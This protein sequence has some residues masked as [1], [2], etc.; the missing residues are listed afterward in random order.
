M[1]QYNKNHPK[2]PFCPF[3]KTSSTCGTFGFRDAI[4]AAIVPTNPNSDNGAATGLIV[5]ALNH[6]LHEVGDG[7]VSSIEQAQQKSE[8]VIQYEKEHGVKLFRTPYEAA[9]EWGNEFNQKS[10]DAGREYGSSIFEVNIEGNDY[11]G[12]NKP[13]IGSNIPDVH[14]RLS[15]KVNLTLPPGS[16]LLA[17]IHSHSTGSLGFSVE[18]KV[19]AVIRGVPTY[20]VNKNWELRLWENIKKEPYFNYYK[21]YK[22]WDSEFSTGQIYKLKKTN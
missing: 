15:V 20:M 6:W 22:L 2:Y 5:T 11:Y 21:E 9:N 14:G 10:I 13:N 8:A 12:Y 7:I 1:F 19:N 4:A 17:T 16:K 3:Y 18:D